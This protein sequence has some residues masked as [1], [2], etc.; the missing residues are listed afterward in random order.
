MSNEKV[1]LTGILSNFYIIA[2]FVNIKAL[3]ALD[4]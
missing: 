4:I 2:D 1:F 3:F